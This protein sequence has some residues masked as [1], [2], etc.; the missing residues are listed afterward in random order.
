MRQSTSKL[1]FDPQDHELL[2]IVNDVALR[3]PVRRKVKSLFSAHL[4]PNGI[5]EMAASKDLRIAHA[6]IHL[7]DSLQAGRMEDRLAALRAV[8]DEVLH[9]AHTPLRNNTGRVLV[10]TM[11]DL[12]RAHG[13]PRRQLEL[14]HD[15]RLASTGKPSMVRKLLDRY[16]LLEMPEDWSQYAF[17][18]HLHDANTKGRKFPT[19]LILDAWIKG[20]RSLTVIH[21]NFVSSEAAAELITAG[22]IM[23]IKVRI[24]VEF[25]ARWHDRYVELIWT[26]RGFSEAVDFVAFLEQ[27]AVARLMADGRQVSEYRQNL[28]LK[29]LRDLCGQLPQNPSCP[30]E[31]APRRFM[32]YVGSGQASLFHLTHFVREI[33]LPE[34]PQTAAGG[35]LPVEPT[36]QELAEAA[37][38]RAERAINFPPVP[39]QPELPG[40]LSLSPC[41]LARTL[42]DLRV[43]SRITLNL[44]DLKVEQV[45]ELLSECRG[46]ITHL[47]I[48]NLKDFVGGKAEHIFAI[49][50]LQ[51][52]LNSGNIIVLK[53]VINE[54]IA[55]VEGQPGPQAALQAQRLRLVLR[56]I[57][58]LRDYYRQSPLKSL[59]GS[60]ST[61]RSATSPGMGLVVRDSLPRRERRRIDR[62][63][64]LFRPALPVHVALKK[65][66]VYH[67]PPRDHPQAQRLW[68]RLGSRLG[69]S[70]L[71]WTSTHDWSQDYLFIQPGTQGNLVSLGGGF[72]G[73]ATPASASQASDSQA[74]PW[75]YLNSG[76]KNGLKVLVG[77]IPAALTFALSRDWWLLAWFGAAIWFGITGLRNILQSVLGGGGVRRSPV[78]GWKNYVDWS[79]LADSLL[80]TGF[81]VP[82]LDWL[83]K[84]VALDQGLGI[85]TTTS[86]WVLYT[87]MAVVNGTY[88]STHNALR[89]LPR[90]AVVGNIFR[91]VLSIPLAF[92]CNWALG[93]LLAH[94][95]V[96]GVDA[97]LQQWA[98]II[99]K[100]ASDCVAGFIEGTADR[101][102]N[103]RMRSWDYRGK[104]AQVFDTCAQL[105]V[106]HPEEKLGDLLSAPLGI[107]HEMDAQTKEQGEILIIHALDLLYFW[108]YQ[109]RAQTMFRHLLKSMTREERLILAQA[110][111]ILACQKEIAQMFVDG[112]VGQHFSR[113]LSFYLQ[114]WAQYLDLCENM[115][116]KLED[117]PAT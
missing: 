9:C 84:T 3:E 67:E 115:I 56:D 38:A 33:L 105:E 101:Y 10:Q 96:A 48:F 39:D 82:L 98:A 23:G 93:L 5:K 107:L 25:S 103:L 2:K 17:D 97:I 50:E 62:R 8:R 64:E 49:N 88:L 37:I 74:R 40:L 34:L 60:D 111:P 87:V 94:L 79:R 59:V 78:L 45:L 15:F 110:Q 29:A 4:H 43:G 66:V 28:V 53:R 55:R 11:K 95:G 81:S 35:T 32:D 58:G 1:L 52:A 31:D 47:E 73:Q 18:H 113:P 22:G 91:S 99:S 51:R 114:R 106:L 76:L 16:H 102:D 46:G 89:G 72:H 7:L 57:S 70:G 69:F 42:A 116:A 90:A 104:L 14:A 117:A 85:N 41:G 108:M 24:G 71:G 100:G 54:I 63:A 44:T 12:V 65:Q 75:A 86:P 26:P 13:N 68:Q 112:L 61:G 30:D 77:F 92:A 109:P 19:H 83:V 6:V 21:Y 27:P 36:P 20:M 80:F